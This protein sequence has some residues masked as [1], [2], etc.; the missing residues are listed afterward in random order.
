MKGLFLRDLYTLRSPIGLLG[1]LFLSMPIIVVL[2]DNGET[3]ILGLGNFCMLGLLI[4]SIIIPSSVMEDEGSGWEKYIITTPGG[5]KAYVL[6]K[7]LDSLIL[8]VFMTLL[9]T[10]AS[11]IVLNRTDSLSAGTLIF[12]V[13]LVLMFFFL[14]SALSTPL[15]FRFGGTIGITC[16]AIMLVLMLC[17]LGTVTVI[18]AIREGDTEWLPNFFEWLRSNQSWLTVVNFCTAA[19]LWFASWKLCCLLYPNKS[20]G[21]RKKTDSASSAA[22]FSVKKIHRGRTG[23]IK[24][25]IIRNLYAV[26][27]PFNIILA[28][29][30]AL[31]FYLLVIGCM[32]LAHTT[33]D[34]SVPALLCAILMLVIVNARILRDRKSGWMKYVAASPVKNSQLVG[35]DFISSVILSLLYLCFFYI[36]QIIMVLQAN[37]EFMPVSSIF[38]GIGTFLGIA[39]VISCLQL[40]FLHSFGN[41]GLAVFLALIFGGFF[42]FS[43]INQQSGEIAKRM[44]EWEMFYMEAN[45]WFVMLAVLT[46]SAAITLVLYFLGVWRCSRRQAA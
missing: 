5:R 19:A 6:Q 45:K 26:L 31:P 32:T 36:P 14:L 33:T 20:S 16:F 46:A 42:C 44:Y 40:F 23:I 21:R 8:G 10:A 34:F 17:A 29:V 2:T 7:H 22:A 11:A 18:G 3:D 25:L 41:A 35:A 1:L 13:S 15:V 9:V 30:L 28:A 27:S 38:T 39:V 24:G 37:D 12:I 4:A 43:I